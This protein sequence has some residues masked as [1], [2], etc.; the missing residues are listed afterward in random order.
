VTILRFEIR[1]TADDR[2]LVNATDTVDTDTQ[3]Q[4]WMVFMSR[5]VDVARLAH[6]RFSPGF[7]H[8]TARPTEDVKPWEQMEFTE[9]EAS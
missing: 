4:P 6:N 2:S 1:I 8:A 9:S 5:I 7:G 3:A